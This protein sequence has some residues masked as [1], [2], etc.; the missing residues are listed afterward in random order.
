MDDICLTAVK[1]FVDL[2]PISG[3]ILKIEYDVQHF[4]IVK[5]FGFWGHDNKF[6][7]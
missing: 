5:T 7:Q 1:I 2:N 4:T 6:C 3:S